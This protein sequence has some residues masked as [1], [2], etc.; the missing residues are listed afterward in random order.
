[1][2]ETKAVNI[3][4][5][6][7]N[8]DHVRAEVARSKETYIKEHFRKYDN[9][10]LPPV[11]KT[12]EVVSFGTLS[13]LFS[14]FADNDVKNDVAADFRLPQFLVLESWLEC[15]T[16]LRNYIAHHARIW[17]RRFPQKPELLRHPS[18]IWIRDRH[19]QPFKLYPILCCIVYW[20]NAIDPT[21]TFV[22][23]F[24]A[25]LLKYPIVNPVLMGFPTSW[26]MK[27]CGSKTSYNQER[28]PSR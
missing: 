17:N 2:D 9:P 1:M 13:K 18:Y 26:G 10:D 5:F 20:L 12:L 3:N 24:K 11:W 4:H 8:L 21:N 7:S 28:Y 27:R 19:F 16:A 22:A 6:H 25:L 15:L 23:D 14:N